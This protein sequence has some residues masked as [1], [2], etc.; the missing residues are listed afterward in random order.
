M[1]S[2]N[3]GRTEFLVRLFDLIGSSDAWG[4]EFGAKIFAQI[5]SLLLPLN[6]GTLI[7]ID[8]AGIHRSDASFQREAIIETLRKH[9]PRLLFVASHLYDPDLRA[10]L[11]LAL[12]KRG[13]VL[14]L[15]E[16]DGQRTILGKRLPLEHQGTLAVVDQARGEFT[17][18]RLT[19]KPYNLGPSTASARLTALWKTGL[20]ERVEGA[21]PGGGKEYR[22]FSIR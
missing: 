22:Y 18:G 15:R 9:R 20:V 5:N 8:Y 14:L 7:V 10:N 21:A 11:E 1:N 16:R 12:Q 13:D 19:L 4:T 6:E 2:M 3:R 17:S